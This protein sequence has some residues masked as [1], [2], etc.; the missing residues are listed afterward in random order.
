MSGPY[1]GCDNGD[2]S[3]ECTYPADELRVYNGTVY[4]EGC[5]DYADEFLTPVPDEIPAY[6]SLDRFVPPDD[7]R[8]MGLE[9]KIRLQDKSISSQTFVLKQLRDYIVHLE[10]VCKDIR[11][12]YA[13]THE[14]H[15]WA[16]DALKKKP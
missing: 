8:I 11:K 14:L 5:W 10:R 2:C 6:F 3:S 9:A 1:W 13:P 7:V 15:Q 16:R 12:T 4:C